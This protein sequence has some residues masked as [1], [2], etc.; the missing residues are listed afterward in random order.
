MVYLLESKLPDKKPVLLALQH[1][2]GIGKFRASLICKR[3]GFSSNLKVMLLSENQII[4]ML[5]IINSLKLLLAH[6]LKKFRLSILKKLVFIRSYR[7]L[8]RKQGLPIRGQRTHTNARTA[9]IIK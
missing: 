1:V 8:R 4:R 9:R 3:L 7:G 5:T 6:E 2:Y